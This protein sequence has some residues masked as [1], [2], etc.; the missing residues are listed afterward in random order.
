MRSSEGSG[1]ASLVVDGVPNVGN[2]HGRWI[3]WHPTARLV[4]PR[5]EEVETL[6]SPSSPLAGKR[7][8]C[9]TSNSRNY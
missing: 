2:K 9:F 1:A 3:R 4:R 8:I 7:S 6:V 5:S